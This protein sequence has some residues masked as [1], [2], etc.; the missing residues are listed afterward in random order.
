MGVLSSPHGGHHD[1]RTAGLL[2]ARDLRGLEA[3]RDRLLAR[4]GALDGDADRDEHA[5][6][7]SALRAA[8]SSA[9]AAADLLRE[10]A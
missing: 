6:A 2:A 4:A 1:L 5:S 7:V 3:H 10:A 8:A 9:D